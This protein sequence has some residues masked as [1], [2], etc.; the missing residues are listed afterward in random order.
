MASSEYVRSATVDDA[1]YL[2][3]LLRMEDRRECLTVTGKAPEDVLPGSVALSTASY[4]IISP[5]TGL[6]I[7]LFGV[8][9]SGLVRRGLV[10]MLATDDLPRYALKFLRSSKRV[11]DSLH[12]HYPHLWNIIDTR[13]ELHMKWVKWCGFKFGR[14][15]LI[16]DVPFLE[17]SKV[18]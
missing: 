13:N 9:P 11:L 12:D 7:G 1:K 6:P 14:H 17:I 10:W 4:T 2:A 16:K 8:S 15:H 3:P 5:D 18:K